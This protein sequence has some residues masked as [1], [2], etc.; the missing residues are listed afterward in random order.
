MTMEINVTTEGLDEVLEMLWLQEEGE[1]LPSSIS[2]EFLRQAQDLKL[3]KLQGGKYEFTN[4]GREAARG[5]I[6]RHR[7]TET[8]LTEILEM[9]DSQAESDACRFEHIMSEQATESVCT[10]LGHPPLCPH[11]KP[12]PRGECCQK[13]KRQL[14]PLVIP[15]TELNSGETCRIVFI[16]PKT[17]SRLDRL[18]SLGIVPGG[19]IKLHQK[20]PTFV[21]RIGETDVALD[22]DVARE[23]YVRRT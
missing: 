18:G 9:E 2:E 17:H 4:K 19:M 23:I 5:I 8:L 13:F 16:T 21:L 12:I 14:T 10:L 11:G 7:L 1:E 3:V 6:R 15:L 22:S 20:R